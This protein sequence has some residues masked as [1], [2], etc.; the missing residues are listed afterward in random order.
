MVLLME[1]SAVPDDERIHLFGALE[2]VRLLCLWM[3]L[4]SKQSITSAI[5]DLSLPI[6]I[7]G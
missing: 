2:M 7:T 3:Q 4:I 6:K 1:Q 5:G